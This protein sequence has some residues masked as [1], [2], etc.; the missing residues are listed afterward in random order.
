MT[1]TLKDVPAFVDFDLQLYT[2]DGTEPITEAVNAGKYRLEVELST[3]NPNYSLSS[4]NLRFEFE[5]DPMEIDINEILSVKNYDRNNSDL[6]YKMFE[7]LDPEIA[8]LIDYQVSGWIEVETETGWIEV[9]DVVFE[10]HYRIPYS[11]IVREDYRSNVTL[12]FGG[13]S[14]YVVNTVCEIYIKKIQP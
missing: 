12:V 14:T 7:N 6:R 3:D 10:G 1:P 11:V 13:N 2:I 9:Q 5:I 4:D 8:M